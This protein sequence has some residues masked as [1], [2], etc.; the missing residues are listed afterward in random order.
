MKNSLFALSLLV[1]A[2]VLAGCGAPSTEM[3][4]QE[5]K[6]FAGGP[7]PANTNEMM[8]KSIEEFRKKHPPQ[9]GS[10]PAPVPSTGH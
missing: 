5:Q 7:R 3:T 8:Q 10:T 4:A 6:N 9:G 2:L 1:G